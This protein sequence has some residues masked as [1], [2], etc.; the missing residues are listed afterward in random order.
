MINLSDQ[1]R[2]MDSVKLRYKIESCIRPDFF[3]ANN[4][5][6]LDGVPRKVPYYFKNFLDRDT[7][8]YVEILGNNRTNL[9]VRAKTHH[10]KINL[11]QIADSISTLELYWEFDHKRRIIQPKDVFGDTDWQEGREVY[12]VLLRYVEDSDIPRILKVDL[13]PPDEDQDLMTSF[14]IV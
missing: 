3:R 13:E 11:Y 8:A 14:R 6:D 12:S 1:L 2:Q 10:P 5:G 7:R 4:V 9:R